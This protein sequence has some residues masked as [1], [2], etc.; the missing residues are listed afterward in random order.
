[1][2]FIK[3]KCLWIS[4]YVSEKWRNKINKI[5]NATDSVSVACLYIFLSSFNKLCALYN[6]YEAESD[7]KELSSKYDKLSKEEN[8]LVAF[9]GQYS[10]GNLRL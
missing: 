2:F 9:V 3:N 1:M 10:S 5:K 6:K 4:H 8:I 7:L